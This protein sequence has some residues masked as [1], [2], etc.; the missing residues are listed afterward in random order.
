MFTL[1]LR[2]ILDTYQFTYT[3]KTYTASP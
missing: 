2:G 1:R 3:M